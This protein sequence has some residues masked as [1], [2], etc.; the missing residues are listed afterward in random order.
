MTLPRVLEPI[1]HTDPRWERFVRSHPE[2]TVYH[3]P[4]WTTILGEAYGFRPAALALARADGE[5]D[6]VFPLLARRR[7]LSGARLRSLPMLPGG[8]PLGRTD[9]D[10]DALVHAAAAAARANGYV[11]FF[12]SRHLG[13]HQIGA[14]LGVIDQVPPNVMTLP[15][16]HD[17]W[18]RDRPK[19]LVRGV[20]RA[21][22]DGVT[23]RLGERTDDLRAFYALYVDTMRTHRAVPRS[24]RQLELARDLLGEHFRL[25]VAEHG[26]RII[27]GGVY[28]AFNGTLELLYSASDPSALEHRPN[29]GLYDHV[30]RWGTEQGL[31]EMDW[32]GAWPEAPL[33]E[34]KAQWGAEPVPEWLYLSSFEPGAHHPNGPAPERDGEGGL[35]GRGAE[36][37]GGALD[38]VPLGLFAAASSAGLRWF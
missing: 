16:D 3:L 7:R 22:K 33:G 4:A 34:F 36:L 13:L 31:R 10:R 30:V 25:F 18:L 6:G 35:R 29:H 8:G 1:G 28:H 12:R 20:K 24:L 17:A 26:G 23:V 15:D 11:L 32:G 27:A 21:R 37:A 14:G 38:H 5:L 2:A 9:A 19:R